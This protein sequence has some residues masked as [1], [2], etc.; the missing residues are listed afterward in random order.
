MDLDNETYLQA[1]Y[2]KVNE[3][4]AGTTQI[5][6]GYNELVKVAQPVRGAGEHEIAKYRLE[7]AAVF[8]AGQLLGY[9]A[10]SGQG[11]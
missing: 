9:Y 5:A 11:S 7:L 8:N 1:E 6:L 10:G 3:I 2:D 4:L